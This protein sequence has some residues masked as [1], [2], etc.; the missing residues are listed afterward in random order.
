[1]A[2]QGVV[3]SGPGWLRGIDIRVEGDHIRHVGVVGPQ[4]RARLMGGAAFVITPSIYLEPFCGVHV[5]AMMTGT[6]VITTDWGAFTKT[7]T[8]G[9]HGF[10][11]RVL[12]EF[13]EAGRRAAYLDRPDIHT[14]AHAMY[15]TKN[16]RH[17]Y[18]AYFQRLATLRGKGWYTVEEAA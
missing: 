9:E 8:D 2:G 3:E 14:F 10:R 13:V 1:V 11:C 16:V 17:Q 15:S 6:P 5:E 18:D 12:S 4:E 7:F